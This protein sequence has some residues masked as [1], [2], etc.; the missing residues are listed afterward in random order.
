MLQDFSTQVNRLTSWAITILAGGPD[1]ADGG[2]IRT[3]GFHLG[4]DTVGNNFSSAYP[5]YREAFL[6]PYSAF[7]HNVFRAYLTFIIMNIKILI[8]VLAQE[9]R[10]K[11]ALPLA[12]GETT[13]WMFEHIG[14]ESSPN[15]NQACMTTIPNETHVDGGG[16]GEEIDGPI[17]GDTLITGGAPITGEAPPSVGDDEDVPGP[18]VGDGSAQ[19]GVSG[20]PVDVEDEDVPGA[21]VGDGSVQ[22]G[23]SGAPV[24]V[25]DDLRKDV[26][27]RI[28]PMG[29]SGILENGTDAL[30]EDVE[31]NRI[32]TDNGSDSLSQTEP[33]VI[34][35]CL[36]DP[37]LLSLPQASIP[38]TTTR[39]IPTVRQKV[40]AGTSDND[41]DLGPRRRRKAANKEIIPL[42]ERC[43]VLPEWL[44]QARGYL[45]REDDDPAWNACIEAWLRFEKDLGYHDV[46]SVSVHSGIRDG[47]HTDRLQGTLA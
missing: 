20:T 18:I 31:G 21:I 7:V 4:R 2:N 22:I 3:V 39:M 33:N 9:M 35:D 5:T 46:T 40:A 11:R 16:G 42:T 27:D 19:R 43:E 37:I 45:Q 1:P 38:T 44:D 15:T 10:D 14:T 25:E 29:E 12:E 47:I 13:V 32:E 8:I 17:A 34:P 30:R 41:E 23:E 24:D 28:L 36:I 26:E 6:K